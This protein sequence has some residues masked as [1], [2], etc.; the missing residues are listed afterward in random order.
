MIIF[1]LLLL[2]TKLQLIL[3]SAQGISADKVLSTQSV[4]DGK[5]KLNLFG[6]KPTQHNF[7]ALIF[8]FT[9]TLS[10]LTNLH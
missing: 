5:G 2:L 9:V 6:L 8:T 3:P 10:V 7:K 1:I 4:N